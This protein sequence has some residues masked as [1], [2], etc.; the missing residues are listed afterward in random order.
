[1]FMIEITSVSRCRLRRRHRS[2]YIIASCC[3]EHADNYSGSNELI[4]PN[5]RAH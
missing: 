1:M 2:E 5:I 4:M 3:F